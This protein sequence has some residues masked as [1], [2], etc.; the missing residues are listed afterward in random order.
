M[1]EEIVS[2]TMEA[3]ADRQT[4]KKHAKQVTC[5][6]GIRGVPTA[7]IARIAAAMWDED[8]PGLPHDR[9][10]LTRVFGGAWEDGLVAVGLLAACTPDDPEEAMDIALEWLERVDDLATADAL[11]WMV[12]GPAWMSLGVPLD[13]L[14]EPT[15]RADHPVRRRAGIMAALALTTERLEGPAA[16]PLRARVGQRQLRFVA[17]AQSAVLDQICTVAVK[18]DDPHVRKGLRRVLRAW[19]KSDAPAV[20]AWG[21]AIAGGLPKL[22]RGE[23]V[24]ARNIARRMAK[25]QAEE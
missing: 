12:L 6:R 23:T 25:L 11:G 20:A 16:A 17:D 24:R 7:E 5:L 13:V 21:E 22:I 18:D 2:E 1:D 14:L 8:P 19:S 3:M 15:L 4:A 10:S 9:G